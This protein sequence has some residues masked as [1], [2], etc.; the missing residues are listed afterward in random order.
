MKDIKVKFSKE[1]N[2]SYNLL[3]D[4]VKKEKNKG[5]KNSFNFQLLKAIDRTI[6]LLKVDPDYGKNIP[7]NLIPK[8]YILDYGINNLRKVNLPNFW[9]LC[10]TIH[11]DSYEIISILLEFMNHND[12]NKKFKYKKK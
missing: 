6:D 5:V 4:E 9:R 10:Y 8:K 12:Y 2:K 3:L 11:T 1:F 7:K